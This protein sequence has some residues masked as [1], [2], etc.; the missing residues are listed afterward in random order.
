MR[1]FTKSRAATVKGFYLKSAGGV[2]ASQGLA[3]VSIEPGTSPDEALAAMAVLGCDED[4]LKC[5]GYDEERAA[6]AIAEA[7]ARE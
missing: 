6:Q 5:F 7:A 4:V 2:D 3:G 1:V